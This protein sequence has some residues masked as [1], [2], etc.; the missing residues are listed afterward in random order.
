MDIEIETPIATEPVVEDELMEYDDDAAIVVDDTPLE[1][2]A[3]ASGEEDTEM[4]DEPVA[5]AP[6]LDM[7]ELAPEAEE[8]VAPEVILA[9][10]EVEESEGTEA[11]VLPVSMPADEATAE[12]ETVE[13]EAAEVVPVQVELDQK[14]AAAETSTATE[15][16]PSQAM[17][18]DFFDYGH[19]DGS[20]DEA[21]HASGSEYYD[22]EEHEYNESDALIDILVA[23]DNIQVPLFS[24]AEGSEGTDQEAL[25][26][27]R[28]DE[29]CHAPLAELLAALRSE[30]ELNESKKDWIQAGEMC[31][32][33]ENMGL[34]VGEVCLSNCFSYKS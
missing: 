15:T 27:G 30:C 4:D 9:D 33:E 21:I 11:A 23:F 25:L 1:V 12:V 17:G 16:S 31:L 22:E 26:D 14:H 20:G 19:H 28:A 34:Y 7:S 29:L 32:E 13:I 10:A 18:S 2:S 5:V 6:E 24:L 3:S 8:V